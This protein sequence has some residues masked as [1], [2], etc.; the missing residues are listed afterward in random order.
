MRIDNL[1]NRLS[2]IESKTTAGLT[3]TTDAS[4]RRCCLKHSGISALREIMHAERQAEEAG[5]EL[6][7]ADLPPELLNELD[8]WSRAELGPQPGALAI[9]VRE[10]AK[11]FLG[12]NQK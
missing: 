9:M 6:T 2:A 5:H 7:R 3:P 8:L 10:Q 12:L 4:G 1:K 11:E